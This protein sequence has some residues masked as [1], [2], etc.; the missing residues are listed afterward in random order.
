MV[1]SVF[2]LGG[3]AEKKKAGM[4]TPPTP[5][6]KTARTKSALEMKCDSAPT[7]REKAICLSAQARELEGLARK[8]DGEARKSE[9]KSVA[10]ERKK[11]E[12]TEKRQARSEKAFRDAIIRSGVTGCPEVWVS[13]SA[14]R[15][16]YG[17]V[18][19]RY[20]IVNGN[21][22]PIE[23]R[24]DATGQVVVR[25]LCPG[26]SMTLTKVMPVWQ[27]GTQ[28]QVSYTATGTISGRPAIAHS[29]TTMLSVYQAQYQ[30]TTLVQWDIRLQLLQ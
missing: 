18:N 4:K 10:I 2:F 7:P 9:P 5:T 22:V 14:V 3:C 13:P 17:F 20:A 25:G 15:P 30:A 1:F 29:P 11:L 27:D 6:T 12:A 26:K 16:A 28:F 23:I 19:A 21:P 24:E 8:A